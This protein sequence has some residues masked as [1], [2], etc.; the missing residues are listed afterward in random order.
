MTSPTCYRDGTVGM[1]LPNAAVELLNRQADG[2]GEI[3][4]KS[5]GLMLGYA[6]DEAFLM[7][8]P[9]QE[10]YDTGDMGRIDSDGFLHI[11]GKRKTASFVLTVR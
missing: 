11:I 7:S 6:D 4:I 3:R 9:Q 8:E 1:P 2:S 10:G 5:S